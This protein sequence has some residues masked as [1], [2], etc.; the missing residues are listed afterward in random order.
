[1]GWFSIF[2][3]SRWGSV[4]LTPMQLVSGEPGLKAAPRGSKTS[5]LTPHSTTFPVV[6]PSLY[7]GLASLGWIWGINLYPWKQK[8]PFRARNWGSLCIQV[9]DSH[10]QMIKFI[11]QEKEGEFSTERL[12]LVYK[13]RKEKLGPIILVR[14][15]IIYDERTVG[16]SWA[17]NHGKT[18][19]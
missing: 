17:W 14:G 1:M 8:F 11:S 15:H 10:L 9:G 5:A 2:P 13:P 18:V 7:K 19:L 4:A 16:P 3:F 12:F 6:H